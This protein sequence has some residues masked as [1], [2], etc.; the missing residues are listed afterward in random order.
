MTLVDVGGVT[1]GIIGAVTQQ[2]PSL[3]DQA[4]IE[5]VEFGDPVAAVNEQASALKE[6]AQPT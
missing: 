1:V 2:T 5:G 3:V 6:A 4:G